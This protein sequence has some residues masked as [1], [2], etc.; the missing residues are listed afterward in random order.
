MNL[1]FILP[2]VNKRAEREENGLGREQ[3]LLHI[4]KF[5]IS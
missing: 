3:Q 1:Y 2:D 5:N 4:I